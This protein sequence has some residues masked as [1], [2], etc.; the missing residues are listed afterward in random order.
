M[1][2]MRP[3]N[4]LF[5]DKIKADR[6]FLEEKK[7]LIYLSNY[8]QHSLI[9]LNND[10]EI[11]YANKTFLDLLEIESDESLIGTELEEVVN[12]IDLVKYD[13]DFNKVEYYKNLDIILS[14]C[15]ISKSEV[16]KECT[17]YLKENKSSEFLVIALPLIISHHNFIILSLID[18]SET[19]WKQTIERIFFHDIL[20]SAGALR[21]CLNLLDVED[22]EGN[23]ELLV[24]SKKISN[25]LIDEITSHKQFLMAERDEYVPDITEFDGYN[26][27]LDVYDKAKYS[28]LA[29][30]KN[31]DI[32]KSEH[33]NISS[34]RTLLSRA[35]FNLVKNALEA[36]NKNGTVELFC[37][38]KGNNIEFI[39]RNVSFIPENHQPNIFTKAFSTKGTGRGLGTYSAKLLT[40]KFLK[41]KVF[42]ESNAETGTTFYAV[43]PQSI[44]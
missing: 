39:V 29:E 32:I 15:K 43:Y 20:N 16:K 2:Q 11:L 37:I 12:C 10:D 5:S 26:I 19:K 41:G 40:E 44:V 4:K 24:V 30:D 36:T 23:E 1:K 42:F 21:E 31:L 14:A 8:V 18:I 28:F 17:I 27:L 34:D 33:I 7:E 3:N 35:I 6:N 22:I 9:I 38:A 13:P 25:N